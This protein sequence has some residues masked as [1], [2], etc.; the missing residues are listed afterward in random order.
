MPADFTGE[1]PEGVDKEGDFVITYFRGCAD[2]ADQDFMH[3]VQCFE[4]ACR[5]LK[6]QFPW[7]EE[8]MLYS[9]G[10]GNFRSLSFELLMAETIAAV[11]LRVVT[12]LLPEAGD[13][14]DR[15]DRDFAGVNNLFASHLKEVGASM[16]NA[17]EMTKALQAGRRKGDGVNNCA[18]EIHRGG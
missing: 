14:K 2:D 8:A 7:V 12:H 5:F 6:I 16:Q 1:I 9:D 4:K 18:L 10:A 11:G 17:V 15:V 3:S 13:G